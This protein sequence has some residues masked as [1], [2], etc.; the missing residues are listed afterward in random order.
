MIAYGQVHQVKAVFYLQVALLYGP[1]VIIPALIGSWLV[2]VLARVLTQPIVKRLLIIGG[3]AALVL[4]LLAVHPVSEADEVAAHEAL[5][6]NQLLRHTNLS[7]SP[8]LPSSW[9]ANSVLGW[10]EG[11]ATQGAFYF[12]VLL[13]AIIRI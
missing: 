12:L 8:I 1:F 9:L 3:A 6:F 13:D 4:L 7:L 2:L 11:L 10:A 5:T